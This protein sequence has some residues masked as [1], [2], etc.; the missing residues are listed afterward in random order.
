MTTVSKVLRCV[1]NNYSN[2]ERTPHLRTDFVIFIFLSFILKSGS[3][4]LTSVA[5]L[6]EI[7]TL[8]NNS[9]ACILKVP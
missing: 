1:T 2:N 5:V 9:I 8:A 7:D 6:V 3:T 4:M